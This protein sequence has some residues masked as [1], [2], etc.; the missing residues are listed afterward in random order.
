MAKLNKIANSLLKKLTIEE[1][2]ELCQGLLGRCA[3]IRYIHTGDDSYPE[4]L[5]H[6]IKTGLR[7]A[8]NEQKAKD[9][10]KEV[11]KV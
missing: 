8:V 4:I 5:A 6:G 9:A 3:A 7:E 10:E 2:E 1:V 11:R